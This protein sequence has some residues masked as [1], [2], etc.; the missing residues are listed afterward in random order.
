MVDMNNSRLWAEG[1][2]CYKVLGVVDEK[3]CSRLWAQD[4][5]FYELLRV[6]DNIT[7]FESW[8]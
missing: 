8:A 5:R 3:K 7:N 6:L 2:R 1:S 4:S